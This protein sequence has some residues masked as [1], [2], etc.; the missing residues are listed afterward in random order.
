M[1]L[2]HLQEKAPFSFL[3]R[4]GPCGLCLPRVGPFANAS[5][6]ALIRIVSITVFITFPSSLRHITVSETLCI[7]IAKITTKVKLDKGPILEK[8]EKKNND[9]TKGAIPRIKTCQ[10]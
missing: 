7:L 10:P 6:T 2:Y 1:S 5:V 4:Q 9:D 8:D 3:Q